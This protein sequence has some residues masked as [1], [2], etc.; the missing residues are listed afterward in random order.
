MTH[1]VDR[2]GLLLTITAMATAV[3]LVTFVAL[4]PFNARAATLAINLA[5]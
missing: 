5:R 4:P 3:S 1:L 2:R